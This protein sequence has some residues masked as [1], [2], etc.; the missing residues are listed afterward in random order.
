MIPFALSR[1]WPSEARATPCRRAPPYR[2]RAKSRI[3]SASI[4]PFDARP[5]TRCARRRARLRAN[6]SQVDD[7]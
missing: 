5:S 2:V 3:P 7:L 6:G 1:R 4:A